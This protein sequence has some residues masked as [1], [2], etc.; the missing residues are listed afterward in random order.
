MVSLCGR[1]FES[2]QLHLHRIDR[3]SP[4]CGKSPVAVFRI[5]HEWCA[6]PRRHAPRGTEPRWRREWPRWKCRGKRHEAVLTAVSGR[7]RYR[8]HRG[9]KHG[10]TLGPSHKIIPNATCLRPRLHDSS[11]RC[12]ALSVRPG[13][14]PASG[15]C[16]LVLQRN[17]QMSWGQPCGCC[18]AAWTSPARP[19][20]SATLVFFFAIISCLFVCYRLMIGFRNYFVISQSMISKQ[21]RT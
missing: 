13:T 5:T 20:G 11:R 17:V 12:T 14:E 8:P 16:L 2:H 19:P 9:W 4:L 6:P 7:G 21:S 10:G 1:G 3:D 15:G 18:C